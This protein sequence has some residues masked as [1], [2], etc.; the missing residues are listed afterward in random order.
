MT[1]SPFERFIEKYD[2]LEKKADDGAWGSIEKLFYFQRDSA[3]AVIEMLKILSET[4]PYV[5]C[6]DSETFLAQ[7]NK[8]AEE[9]MGAQA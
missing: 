7:L 6:Y 4:L 3:K 1:K 9:A 5:E 8:L 2:E